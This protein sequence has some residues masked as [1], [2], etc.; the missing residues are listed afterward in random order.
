MVSEA[1]NVNCITALVLLSLV[2]TEQG[3]I[4]DTKPS[5]NQLL[6][7][8]DYPNTS[9]FANQANQASKFLADILANN[10]GT[11]RSGSP[12]TIPLS[13]D[14]ACGT[15]TFTIQNNATAALYSYVGYAPN[16]A[17]INAG[18]G[19]GDNCSAYAVRNFFGYYGQW[20]GPY[21]AGAPRLDVR[22]VYRF[23][24]MPGDT[25]FWTADAYEKDQMIQAGYRYEDIGWR[26]P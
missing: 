2:E 7:A 8:F 17:A 3:L 14:P 12:S 11:Y 22:Y 19:A 18:M 5:P 15:V 16:P 1:A 6:T 24:G 25:H 9:G 23:G 20:F 10:N 21:V 4:T 26:I 13:S